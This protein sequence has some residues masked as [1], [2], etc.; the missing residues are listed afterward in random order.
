MQLNKNIS[1]FVV[2]PSLVVVI[3][4]LPP[5]DG[6]NVLVLCNIFGMYNEYQRELINEVGL[7]EY[8]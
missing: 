4:L 7:Y 1:L 3:I 2:R 6:R 5:P 8:L